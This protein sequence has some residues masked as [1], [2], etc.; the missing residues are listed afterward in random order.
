VDQ[1][2]AHWKFG[3]KGTL[4]YLIKWK[5]YPKSDNT[6]ENTDQIHAPVLIK[7]YH[8]TNA[9]DSIK[10][11]RVQPKR[12]PLHTLAPP[13]NFSPTIPYSPIILRDNTS[14]LVWSTAHENN[15]RLACS[16]H[17]PPAQPLLVPPHHTMLPT[18]CVTLMAW[19]SILQTSTMCHQPWGSA[20]ASTLVSSGNWP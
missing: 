20:R 18:S 6:W 11:Q 1:I 14:A 15:I 10:A 8:Q 12:H 19:T 17:D 13:K 16:L 7:L 2:H 3:H 5:G 9:Q 4:Q